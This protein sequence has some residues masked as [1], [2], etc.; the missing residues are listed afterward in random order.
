MYCPNCGKEVADNTTFCPECGKKIDGSSGNARPANSLP[1]KSPPKLVPF[2]LGL[3]LGLIG[4][5]LAVVIYSSSSDQYEGNATTSALLWS[6]FGILFWFIIGAVF[7][8][9]II[10]A[11]IASESSSE[12]ISLF[13]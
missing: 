4:L 6:I 13:F 2:L 1:L 8:V 5:I 11:G 10:G 3:I 12:I 7:I 9:L